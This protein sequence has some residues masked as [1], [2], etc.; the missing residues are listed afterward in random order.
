MTTG[1]R[2]QASVLST[3][4]LYKQVDECCWCVKMFFHLD[5]GPYPPVFLKHEKMLP[6]VQVR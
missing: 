3:Y 2:T 6:I 5:S 1:L 4:W